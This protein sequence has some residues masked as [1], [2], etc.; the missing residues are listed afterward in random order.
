MPRVV[1][2]EEAEEQ[3]TATSSDEMVEE[4]L[5]LAAGLAR[6]PERG[7]RVPELHGQPEHEIVRE[8][9]LPHKARVF[10]L[11]VPDSDEVIILGLLPR[12]GVFRTRVLGPRF[13]KD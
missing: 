7:R 2:T 4:L 9:I 12:G 3:L 8:V 13:E 1:W 10:Y 5:A 6:F 11:F